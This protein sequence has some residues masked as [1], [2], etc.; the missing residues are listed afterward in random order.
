MA[1]LVGLQ[2]EIDELTQ[3]K[4]ALE[5]E[6]KR[7][8]RSTTRLQEL[9]EMVR[10]GVLFGLK[11]RYVALILLSLVGAT[12][13]VVWLSFRDHAFDVKTASKQRIKHISRSMQPHL[14]VTSDPSGARVII[15]GQLVGKTPLAK[16]AA[17]NAKRRFGVE[18]EH[19]GYHK[20]LQMVE[21]SPRGGA[22]LHAVLDKIPPPEKPRVVEPW[23]PPQPDCSVPT[24]CGYEIVRGQKAP[25]SKK[26]A[27]R[28]PRTTK[29]A[30]PGPAK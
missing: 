30:G 20:V 24:A 17:K 22:H 5:P 19:P 28:R 9:V 27:A 7:L 12:S 4:A 14:L 1:D 15:N 11:K 2:A 13:V 29:K 23:N 18:I 3:T 16:T 21:T 26:T 8:T 6:V 10:G 25:G